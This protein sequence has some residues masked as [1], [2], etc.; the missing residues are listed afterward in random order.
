MRRVR[1]WRYPD[2]GGGRTKYRGR[3]T[4]RNPWRP[5]REGIRFRGRPGTRGNDLRLPDT[6]GNRHLPDLLQPRSDGY[7]NMSFLLG[8]SNWILASNAHMNPWVHLE[9]RSQNFRDV[10]PNTSVVTEMRVLD[11]YNRKGHEFVDVDVA[12]FDEDTSASCRL[13][14]TL[15]PACSLNPFRILLHQKLQLLRYL[16]NCSDCY[17]PERQLPGGNFTH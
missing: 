17:R 1:E 2:L 13:L 4:E 5:N 9:T 11:F 15:R 6:S 12:L 14:G 16:H 3:F 7:A 10:P 8:C